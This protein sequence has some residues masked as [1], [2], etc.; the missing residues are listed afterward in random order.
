M[1]KNTDLSLPLVSVIIPFLNRIKLTHRAVDS[2]LSQTYNNYE[3]IVINDGSDEDALELC[4]YLAGIEKC[5]YIELKKNQGPAEARN[6]GIRHSKGEFIAF[7]DSDDTWEMDKLYI[8]INQMINNNWSFSH[9]T[10]RRHESVNGRIKLVRSGLHHYVYPWPAFRCLIATPSVVIKRELIDGLWFRPELRFA[11]DTFLWLELS[12]RTILHGID[13]PLTNVFTGDLTTALN[14]SIQEKALKLLGREGLSGKWTLL[15][16]HF[17]Y[18]QI[19]KI[20]RKVWKA[21]CSNKNLL[22]HSK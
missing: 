20:Q 4:E 17:I 7:L 22:K 19:R 2:V 5:T 15:T 16:I 11:E 1:I 9:T 13:T 10:Y 12:K 3:I 8:Q 14:Q 6:V 21:I 18:R